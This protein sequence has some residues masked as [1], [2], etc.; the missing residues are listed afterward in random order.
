MCCIHYRHVGGQ[1]STWLDRAKEYNGGRYSESYV[2]N[3]KALTRLLPLCILQVLYRICITQVASGYF[4]QSMNTNLS[5]NGV[6]LPIAVMKILSIIPILILAP[7]LES[8]NS[9]L[10]SRRGYGLQPG[11][12]I[13]C[14]H[15][16]AAFSLF[17]AGIY[18]I[19][20]KWFPL[21]EQTLSGKVLLVSSMSCLHLAPQYALLGV[22]E[23]MVAPA[24]SFI[25]FR[26]APIRI[27]SI[28]MAVMTL[29]QAMG[30]FLGA[31]LIR[32]VFIASE[33]D[34]YPTILS[35]GHLERFFFVLASAMLLNSLAF[36]RISHR[37]RDLD[38]HS[39]Q[40][41]R[42]SLLEEN[43]LLHEKSLKFYDSV[44]DW[45][46]PYTPMETRL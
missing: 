30:C 14:G 6:L 26:L 45:P 22:A 32:S 2:E 12:S 37:Y 46:S 35:N 10:F 3:T 19:H 7:C 44:L 29:F 15:V 43:L 1:V 16:G 39:D 17:V 11:T 9:F 5:L 8:I 41:F 20:R 28:C 33:G 18:E 23:A 25:I 36:W 27:R 34:W 31:L 38:E 13:V 21:V 4:I 24:C 40:G 42:Q